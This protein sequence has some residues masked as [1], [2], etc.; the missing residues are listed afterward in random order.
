[1]QRQGCTLK[2]GGEDLGVHTAVT[3]GGGGRD[4]ECRQG[5]RC[6]GVHC[7]LY[8]QGVVSDKRVETGVKRH[9]HILYCTVDTG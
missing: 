3:G 2:K 7:T 6:T 1:M 4:G 5:K 8:R 9:M